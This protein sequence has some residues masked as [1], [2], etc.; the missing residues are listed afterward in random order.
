MI[1]LPGFLI[2]LFSGD[3]E[4]KWFMTEDK[5]WWDMVVRIEEGE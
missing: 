5:N 4:I 3:K 1:P 2:E